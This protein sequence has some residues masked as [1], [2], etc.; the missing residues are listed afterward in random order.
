MGAGRQVMLP[1]PP[2][3][4]GSYEPVIIR[5]GIGTVSGQFPI[6]DGRLAFEGRLGAELTINAGR[7]AARLAALNV[8]AQITAATDGFA[9]LDGLLRLEGY[10]ASAD[11]FHDQPD[12]LDAASTCFIEALAER[13]RHTRAAF[14]VQ[15]L[16]L[17]APIELV[18]SFTTQ[19]ESESVQGSLRP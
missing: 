14:A 13:G 12:I 6:R 17:N 11:G 15:F 10:V 5:R 3:P 16:P 19:D 2:R 18:L 9:R 4:V 7:E 8:L 1:T